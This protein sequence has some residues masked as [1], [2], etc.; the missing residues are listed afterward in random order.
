V[1]AVLRW[2]IPLAI[3]LAGLAIAMLGLHAS[4]M[5]AVY[6]AAVTPELARVDLHEHRLPNR[7]VTPG[8]ALGVIACGLQLSPVPPLAALAFGGLLLVAGLAGGVGMGDVK[9]A[10]LI[11]L[12]SP[13]L[14]VAVAAPLAAFLIGGVA[15]LVVLLRRGP[16]A[17]LAFGPAL[18]AGY[19]VAVLVAGLVPTLGSGAP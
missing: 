19:W 9:L 5:P 8:L 14:A 7:M 11:G 17:R 15:A 10:A 16:R 12:A 1:D 18:L 13:T 6:L 3:V 2:Q 4:T